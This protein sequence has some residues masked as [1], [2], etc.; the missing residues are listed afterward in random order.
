MPRRE[1][2][3]SQLNSL[4]WPMSFVSRI[5]LLY[6]GAGA[7][8]LGCKDVTSARRDLTAGTTA[9]RPASTLSC[10]PPAPV[11]ATC[12]RPRASSPHRARGR[13]RR[14]RVQTDP[15]HHVARLAVRACAERPVC[16]TFHERNVHVWLRPTPHRRHARGVG[17]P[18]LAARETPPGGAQPF[19]PKRLAQNIKLSRRY[20]LLPPSRWS[21]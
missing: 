7:A 12:S 4:R 19:A 15:R 5:S 1:T 11:G 9:D 18:Y 3:G 8:S 10:L 2:R 17:R 16:P 21:G 14:H 13:Q 6:R 20:P